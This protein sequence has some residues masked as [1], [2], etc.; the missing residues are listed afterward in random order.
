MVTMLLQTM[1]E[2]SSSTGI[3]THLI[4]PIEFGAL[5]IPCNSVKALLKPFGASPKDTDDSGND[6]EDNE[7]GSEMFSED[8]EDGKGDV[9]DEDQDQDVA[10][11][12]GLGVEDVDEE[13]DPFGL[14]D[15]EECKQLLEDTLAVCST[16]N[17][18][19]THFFL[20][21]SCHFTH[22]YSLKIRKLSFVIIHSTTKALPAWCKACTAHKLPV[23]LIP[24][25]MKICWNS[26][27]DIVKMAYK[28]C[29]TIDNIA[30]N[31]SLK[32]CKYELDDDDWKVIGDL[33]QVL[34]VGF[35][36]NEVLFWC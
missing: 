17:K 18:V 16:L 29:L 30:A 22:I 8:L 1:S 13:E 3:P 25:D 5:I 35:S 33:L 11:D 10:D 9:E 21:I 24:W 15:E 4:A 34:K 36:S 7:G 26:T 19:F 12:E 6:D 32:L 2:Q 31:K 28:F 27:Y 23:H 14:L 20:L